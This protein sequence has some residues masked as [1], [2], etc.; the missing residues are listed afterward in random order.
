M[1]LAVIIGSTRRGRFGPTVAHWL[2]QQAAKQFEIDIVD[3]A[4]ADLP[5]TLPDTDDETPAQVAVLALRLAA[6]LA[7]VHGHPRLPRTA[8]R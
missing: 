2:A 5:T 4:A 3:L 8:K 1:R 6:A 7:I